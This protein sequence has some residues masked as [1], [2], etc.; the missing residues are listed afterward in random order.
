MDGIINPISFPLIRK[1]S[2]SIALDKAVFFAILAKTWGIV[3]TPVTFLLIARHLSPELQG[4]HYTF[5]SLLALQSFFELG[6]SLVITQ[7]ASHEWAHLH[8]NEAGIIAGEERSLSRLISLG[9]LVVKWYAVAS[10]IFVITVGLAGYLF[11]NHAS[12]VNISWEGPW[13]MLVFFVGLQLWILPIFSLLEGCHQIARVNLFRLISSFFM[14]CSFWLVLSSGGNLW[15][16]AISFG[17]AILTQLI[18]LIFFYRKFFIPF[19]SHPTSAHM[20]WKNEIWPMQWRLGM[21]GLV[22]YFAFSLFNPVMF[23]YHGATVAGQMGMTIQAISSIGAVAYVWIQAKVPTMG[24]LVAQK[25]YPELDHL[26]FHISLISLG[27]ILLGTGSFFALLRLLAMWHHPLADRFLP[28]L[29]T[30]LFLAAAVFMQIAQ[31]AAA[32]LRAHKQEPIV[33]MSVISSLLIGL[34]VWLWGRNYGPTG[35]AFSYFAIVSLLIVPWLT[36]I[37][38]RCRQEWHQ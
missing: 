37:W 25:K 27:V 9:R 20:D 22:N 18:L 1:L 3:A 34:F 10:T 32:Y 6:F 26:F 7:F 5:S 38:K 19:F 29:P 16:S 12:K 35:A 24:N 33:V 13:F 11:F 30:A 15:S 21:S 14:A 31:C 23:H 4:F 36:F 2:H 8:L 28:P 17:T